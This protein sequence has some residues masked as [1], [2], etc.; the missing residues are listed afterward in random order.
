[1]ESQK[2]VIATIGSLGDLH[3]AMALALELK[4]RGH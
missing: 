1:M 3:P 2:I 4:A